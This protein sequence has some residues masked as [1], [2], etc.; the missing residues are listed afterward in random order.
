MTLSEADTYER[1]E[2]LC[3]RVITQLGRIEAILGIVGGG[4]TECYDIQVFSEA[5]TELENAIIERYVPFAQ[6]VNS[7][8]R[9]M[10]QKVLSAPKYQIK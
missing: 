10:I 4:L 1:R 2:Q 6:S 5:L 3:N 9:D 7:R 8:T